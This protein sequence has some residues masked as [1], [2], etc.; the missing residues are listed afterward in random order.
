MTNARDELYDALSSA[1]EGSLLQTMIGYVAKESS[2]Q[3]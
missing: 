1:L 2:A 3:V